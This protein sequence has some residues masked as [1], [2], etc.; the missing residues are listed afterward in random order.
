M[1]PK[2]DYDILFRSDSVILAF[3]PL[4]MVADSA[5]HPYGRMLYF[6]IAREDGL[7]LSSQTIRIPNGARYYYFRRDMKKG[8]SEYGSKAPIAKCGLRD[9]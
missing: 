3:D 5:A 1:S 7:V 8:T 6:H 4:A 9:S 2:V